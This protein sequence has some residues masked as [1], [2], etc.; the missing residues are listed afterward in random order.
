MANLKSK[1]VL[2]P[3]K[4]II[5]HGASNRVPAVEIWNAVAHHADGEWN[6]D[7]GTDRPLGE[8]GSGGVLRLISGY[9]A[10]NGEQLLVISEAEGLMT[11]VLLAEEY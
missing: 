10:S 4:L 1:L 11:T 3:G 5:T 7:V 2:C 9:R 8:K 6:E